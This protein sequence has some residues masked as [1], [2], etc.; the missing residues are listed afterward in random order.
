MYQQKANFIENSLC[1]TPNCNML[2]SVRDCVN[3]SPTISPVAPETRIKPVKEKNLFFK[4]L[5]LK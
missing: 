1:T 2:V 5:L 3:A 4:N